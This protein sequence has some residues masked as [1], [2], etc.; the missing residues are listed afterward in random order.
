MNLYLRLLLIWLQAR[1]QGPARPEKPALTA[2][3]VWPTD[4]DVFGHMNNGRYLQIMDLSRFNWMARCGVVS[5]M[6]RHG[7]GAVLGGS[8]VRFR[9]SL[10]VLETYEVDTRLVH[11]DKRWFYI[12]HQFLTAQGRIAAVGCSRAALRQAGQWVSPDEVVSAVAP[13]TKLVPPPN[14]VDLWNTAEDELFKAG[15]TAVNPSGGDTR[16]SPSHSPVEP[17]RRNFS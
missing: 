10:R 8:V 3:R 11:W 6:R 17:R 7:W 12:E 9:H 5:A 15:E 13:G 2:F 16:F 4:I 14:Y 1:R